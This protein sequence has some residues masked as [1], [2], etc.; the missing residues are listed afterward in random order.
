MSV[1]RPKI[2]AAL[3]LGTHNCRLSIA[4]AYEEKR[5]FK[6]IERFSRHVL[7]GQGLTASGYLSDQAMER[8]IVALALCQRK[9][10]KY[11]IAKQRYVATQACRLAVNRDFFIAQVYE[12]T[13]ITLEIIDNQT[14]ASLAAFACASLIKRTAQPAIVFDIGGGSSQISLVDNRL[15]PEFIVDWLSLSFGVVNLAEKFSLIDSI[16]QKFLL[17]QQEVRLAL[18]NIVKNRPLAALNEP[19]Y[20]LG[21]SG[22]ATTLA[23]LHLGLEKYDKAKIDGLRLKRSRVEQ[24]ITE[25]L[26]RS[27]QETRLSLYSGRQRAELLLAGCAI[28]SCIIEF[29]PSET[30]VVA[31]RGVRDGILAQFITGQDS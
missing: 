30:V 9:I 10:A 29:W 28:L 2:Y 31:D 25:I 1:V 13:G 4:K 19:Y 20:L 3:D 6:V 23:G 18:K 15:K 24:L 27:N 8:A 14:E 11:N 26:N 21:M 16:E 12:K 17:M 22:T 7:L 5:R